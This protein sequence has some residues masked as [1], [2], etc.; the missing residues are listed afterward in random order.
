MIKTILIMGCGSIGQRHAKNAKNI[1][2]ENIILFDINLERIKG[3]AEEISTDLLYDSMDDLF[4]ENPKI[5]AA[6]ISTPSALHVD[7]AKLLAEH[8]INL[9]IEKPLSNT[10]DGINQLIKLIEE[11]NLTTMMGQSYRFH[12]GFIQLKK[13]LDTDVV[14]KIYHVNYYG[15]QYLPDWHPTMDY[16]KE[17]SAR[18]ELGGGVLL[19]TMSHMFDNIQWLFGDITDIN[20]WKA[21]LSD[22]EIDVEDSVFLLLKTQK[23]IIINTYF[24]FIQRCQQHKMI[25]TGS[26]GHIEADFIEHEIKVCKNNSQL[27]LPYDF[28]VNKRYVMELQHFL[29]LVDKGVKKHEIDLKVGKK[30]L[31]YIFNPKIVPITK[32]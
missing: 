29:D 12:E 7:N 16:R 23:N 2:V 3:F 25:I 14:G 4:V 17:Y 24:D 30:V 8:S 28:D 21:N 6:V 1:G 20:G 13:L 15:G 22:L 18:K 5:D 9:F 31:E 19:T 32:I 11:K 26:E 10:L 27:I